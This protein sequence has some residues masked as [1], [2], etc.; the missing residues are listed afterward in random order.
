MATKTGS[1]PSDAGSSTASEHTHRSRAFT[2][3]RCRIQIDV[4][5]AVGLE[6]FAAAIRP[7]EFGM[8]FLDMPG[9]SATGSQGFPDG[10]EQG[11]RVESA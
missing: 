2:A 11:I 1:M 9:A 4:S 10:A 3:G 5:E 6:T 8:H 7:C